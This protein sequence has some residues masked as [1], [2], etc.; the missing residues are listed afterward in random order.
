MEIIIQKATSDSTRCFPTTNLACCSTKML[1]TNQVKDS[2]LMI[3]FLLLAYPWLVESQEPQNPETTDPTYMEVK[4]W[5]SKEL[6]NE[7]E[8]N[9]P[10]NWLAIGLIFG[11]LSFAVLLIIALVSFIFLGFDDT[12]KN[13]LS[14]HCVHMRLQKEETE[15]RSGELVEHRGHRH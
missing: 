8:R 12:S 6:V 4:K 9:P 10:K 15:A 7:A 11:G 13:F 2:F 1:Y 3:L 5:F 14:D